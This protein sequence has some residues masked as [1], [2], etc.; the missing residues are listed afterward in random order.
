M[1]KHERGMSFWPFVITLI[2]LLVF[3]F[4][5]FSQKSDTDEAVKAR[6]VAESNSKARTEAATAWELYIE[7]LAKVVGFQDQKT[8]IEVKDDKGTVVYTYT[9]PIPNVETIEKT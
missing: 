7:R 1:H 4:M 3:V 8:P 5:W 9:K 6:L 2:L